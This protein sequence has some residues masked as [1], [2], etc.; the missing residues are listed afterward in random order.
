MA[1]NLTAAS[2]I[3]KT[4]YIG[5][6]REQLNGATVL[7][8]KIGRQDQMVSGKDFTAPL[9]TGRNVSAGYGIADGGTLPTAGQQSYTTTVVP[10][11]YLYGRIEVSGPTIA[12]TRD[13]MGAFVEALNS[14]VDM[15]MN[16]FKKNM[17]RQLNSDGSGALAFLTAAADTAGAGAWGNLTAVDDSI[18]N[19]FTYLESAVAMTCDLIDATDGTTYLGQ[20]HVIT[21]GAE[22]TTTYTVSA[23]AGAAV[24]GSADGDYFIRNGARGLEMMGIAG[25]ISAANTTASSGATSLQGL[26]VASYPFWTA[27]IIG[28]YASTRAIAFEDIQS[29]ID[30]VEEKSNY[31]AKDIGVLYSNFGVRRAYYKLCIAER[32]AV[33]TMEL[34]GGWKAID[35]SGTPWVVDSQ[36][37]RSTLFFVNFD[38]MQI[39]RT[40]DFD[41]MDKDGSYLSRVAN[42][43]AYEAVLFHYGNLAALSRNGNGAIFGIIEA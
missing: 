33:N 14:E 15:L 23:T 8:D 20:A 7:L 32:R 39:F 6:I 1:M 19:A 5:K 41:W 2:S 26:A 40:S 10:N 28:S 35:F 16:D 34:D 27:Q 31:T 30:K 37:R 38:T 13:N 21:L 12:A 24:S 29:I 3:L 25:I 4:R 22:G 9:H 43:D 17:N 36:A 18:G 42:K 11:R